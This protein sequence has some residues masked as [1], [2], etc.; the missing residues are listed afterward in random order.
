MATIDREPP[1]SAMAGTLVVARMALQELRSHRSEVPAHL[2]AIVDDA[3]R[4]VG[5]LE[6]PDGAYMTAAHLLN[7]APSLQ[8][9]GLEAI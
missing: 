5:P 2:A 8:E 1:A 6:L 7:R 9:R 3:W 4:V